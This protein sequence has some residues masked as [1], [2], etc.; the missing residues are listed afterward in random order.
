MTPEQRYAAI[1]STIWWWLPVRWTNGSAWFE[2]GFGVTETG[3]DVLVSKDGAASVIVTFTDAELLGEGRLTP[4]AARAR[5]E[6]V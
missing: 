3:A 6:A 5:I 1:T 2:V 4:A